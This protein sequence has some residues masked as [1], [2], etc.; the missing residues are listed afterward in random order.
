MTTST[1]TAQIGHHIVVSLTIIK[2]FI[3]GPD[4]A[5]SVGPTITLQTDTGKRYPSNMPKIKYQTYNFRAEA[6]AIVFQANT[7]LQEYASRGIVLTLRSLYY[8]FV[9][10]DLIQNKQSEYKKLGSIINDA[11]LAGL[12]DWNHLQDR[13]RNLQRLS[14]WTDPSHLIYSAARGYHKN[15]W[16]GQDEYVEIWIEKD[17]LIGTIEAICEEW[18]VPYFSCR[19]Y[20]SQSEMWSAGQ[21]LVREVLDNRD[22]TII[23]LGDHDPSGKDMSRDILDRLILFVKYHTGKR[24]NVERIALNMD[25]IRQYNPPPNFAKITDTRAG[26]YIEEFGDESWELDALDPD[27]MIELIRTNILEHLDVDLWTEKRD[28]M[29]Q[30]REIL[31]TA[32]KRWDDIVEF[33][34]TE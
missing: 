19:G 30:E 8:Q 12:I 3:Q 27:V 22:V 15:L 28:Q 18:D 10:R 31:S 4:F 2:D 20:T 7:I 9:S 5:K 16:E 32:S 11:R 6:L 13:T 26:K 29:E 23:H 14:S 34:E 17:A 33:L 1:S 21:R 24:I 25:Q